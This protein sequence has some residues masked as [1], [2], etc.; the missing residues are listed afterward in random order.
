MTKNRHSAEQ[1]KN[2][3]SYLTNLQSKIPAEARVVRFTLSD[4]IQENGQ[5]DGKSPVTAIGNGLNFLASNL[6]EE[7][8]QRVILLSDGASNLGTNPVGEAKKLGVP[9]TTVGFGNPNPLPD[10]TIAEVNCNPV[11]FAARNSRWRSSSSQEALRICEC[12]S[13]SAATRKSW[14]KKRSTRRKR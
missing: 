12:L 9:V 6:E 1:F 11:A 13:E 14:L 8:L 5:L 10:I 4:T 3:E 7:N 2:M